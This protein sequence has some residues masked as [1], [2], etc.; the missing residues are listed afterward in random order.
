[1]AEPRIYP[2]DPPVDGLT[3]GHCADPIMATAEVRGTGMSISGLRE[4]LWLHVHGSDVC[5]PTT[6]ARPYDG[7]R[8]TE[9]VRAVLAARD[10][11]EDALLDAMEDR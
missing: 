7:W 8:A 11:A 5:R 4:Y 10:A 9:H 2:I 1:M 3:C 6:T